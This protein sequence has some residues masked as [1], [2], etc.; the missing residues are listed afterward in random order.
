KDDKLDVD[1]S[2]ID[3][4]ELYAISTNGEQNF[5]PD[6]QKAAQIELQRRFDQ[7]LAGP[8]S[9]GRVTGKI[10]GLYTAALAFLDLAGPEE[11]ASAAHVDARKAVEA[12]IARL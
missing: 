6:E 2:R 10:D 3:R 8:T 5:T 9:V 7:A 11:K 4:R 12:M 1:L